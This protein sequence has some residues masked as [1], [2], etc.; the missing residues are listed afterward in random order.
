[1]DRTE[2]WLLRLC[3]LLVLPGMG[4][5]AAGSLKDRLRGFDILTP[6]DFAHKI[7]KRATVASE[8]LYNDIEDMRFSALDRKFRLT[9]FPKKGL[10]TSDFEITLTDGHGRT[11][12]AVVDKTTFFG[13]HVF[14]EKDSEVNLHVKDNQLVG[15]IRTEDDTFYFEPADLHLP[16]ESNATLV[17]RKSDI[18]KMPEDGNSEHR[19]CGF[20]EA[21]QDYLLGDSDDSAADLHPIRNRRDVASFSPTHT[22]C[23]LRLVA[24]F[25]F[26]NSVGGKS[27]KRTITY[28][29]NV[30]DRVNGIYNST[31]WNEGHEQDPLIGYGFVIQAINILT[32]PTLP[33]AGDHHYNDQVTGRTSKEILDL[34]SRDSNHEKFCLAHLFTDQTLESGVL[35]LAY[36]G[37]G[38]SGSAGG[39][40]SAPYVKDGRA[41][42]LNSGLT[43]ARN[44]YDQIVITREMELVTAHELGHNW[45]SQHDPENKDCTPDSRAG[46]RFLMYMYSVSGLESNNKFFSP[47]S[48]RSVRVVLLSKAA[49]CFFRPEKSLCGN[50]L[51]E[52]GEQCDAGYIGAEDKDACCD[53]RCKLR[54]DAICSDKNSVCCSN[55]KY[56]PTSMK[57]SEMSVE[58]CQDA[59]FCPGNNSEC[60]KPGPAPDGQKCFDDGECK[61]GHCLS[62]CETKGQLSCVCDN[63]MESC[64]VCCR[65]QNETCHPYNF[66]L[67]PQ[68]IKYKAVP[69]GRSCIQGHC[70][71]GNCKQ[72]IQDFAARVW[73]VIERIDFSNFAAFLKN[74]IVGAVIILSLIVWIPASCIVHNIDKKFKKE[75]SQEFNRLKRTVSSRMNSNTEANRTLSKEQRH[76]LAPASSSRPL[77]TNR[78]VSP[79]SAA[80]RPRSKSPTIAN[81]VIRA[82]DMHKLNKKNGS[83][84]PPTPKT[85]PTKEAE[86]IV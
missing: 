66:A 72:S 68:E 64:Q 38:R 78:A 19:T 15:S 34:F 47:C 54:P 46:G 41:M 2:F 79:S 22:R 62:F 18:I 85:T 1:M 51:V 61:N 84:S 81:V 11:T 28:L 4:K 26:F 65:R 23:G 33:K 53:Q 67:K 6:D 43:T 8:N 73:L 40:C 55:C 59:A 50:F 36:V 60:P 82:H 77:A 56:S 69:N 3:C 24:D 58:T 86:S 16:V 35:G 44:N 5:S 12:P 37:N 83:R 31:N 80:G 14:G 13:G 45:G 21:D 25:R 7:V 10:F 32:E 30:I 70:S 29:I 52:D 42:F 48:R 75:H 74:N 71:N 27:P 76:L 57:C 39:I 17:Y 20:V 9:L 49:S 63:I